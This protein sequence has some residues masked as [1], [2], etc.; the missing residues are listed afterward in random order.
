MHV[1]KW[2]YNDNED[3]RPI[4][5]TIIY[6]LICQSL[7]HVDL[8]SLFFVTKLKIYWCYVTPC[9]LFLIAK[10]TKDISKKVSMIIIKG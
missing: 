1:H 5:D 3:L 2:Y 8:F 6:S 4:D 7:L 9:F 10:K